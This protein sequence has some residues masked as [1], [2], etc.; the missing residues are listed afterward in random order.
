MS[1]KVNFHS[2]KKQKQKLLSRLQD[3]WFLLDSEGAMLERVET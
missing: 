1:P 3:H 2:W